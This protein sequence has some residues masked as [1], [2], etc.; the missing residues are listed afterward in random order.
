VLARIWEGYGLEDL[1][2]PEYRELSFSNDKAS[3]DRECV[4]A[5][6]RRRLAEAGRAVQ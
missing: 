6:A 2:L 1:A 3:H 5:A 4:A